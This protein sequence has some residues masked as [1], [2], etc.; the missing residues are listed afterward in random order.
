ME[1]FLVLHLLDEIGDSPLDISHGLVFPEKDLFEF[2]VFE[3]AL[4][5]SVV[6]R[7]T[8]ARHTDTETV[9]SKYLHVLMSGILNP[10]VGVVNASWRWLSVSKGDLQGFQGQGRPQAFDPGHNPELCGNAYP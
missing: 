8:L 3:K 9:L 1:P 7:I 2:Q 4:H 6:K 5:H 10:L